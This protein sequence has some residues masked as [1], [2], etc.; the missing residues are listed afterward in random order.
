MTPV[1]AGSRRTRSKVLDAETCASVGN[2]SV[3]VRLSHH[4]LLSRDNPRFG[5]IPESVWRRQ[6]SMDSAVDDHEV[7][8]GSGWC[9]LHD[10]FSGCLQHR[11]KGALQVGGMAFQGSMG[12]STSRIFLQAVSSRIASSFRPTEITL[13]PSQITWPSQEKYEKWATCLERNGFHRFGS[14]ASPETNLKLEFWLNDQRNFAPK[15]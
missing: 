8:S 1:G 7:R 13:D 14:F 3:A 12:F 9:P 6:N 5:C 4:R 15:L 10:S 11:S 2:Y